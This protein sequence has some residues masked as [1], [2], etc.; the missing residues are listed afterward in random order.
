MPKTT[1]GRAI[2]R[3]E[4]LGFSLI[5]ALVWIMELIHLPHLVLGE[6]AV[7]NW[8][9]VLIRT[10]IVSAVWIWVHLRT[11]RLLKR[12]HQLEDFLLICSWCRKVGH[13]GHWLTTE[14]YFGSNFSTETSH[15]ICPECAK[16]LNRNFEEKIAEA[17][18]NH[19]DI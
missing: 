14:E 5:T 11:R 7:F 13:E 1:S 6:P 19:P 16:T 3:S 9:R 12:L 2:L 18:R 10:A 8:P 17:K 15:G 4:T